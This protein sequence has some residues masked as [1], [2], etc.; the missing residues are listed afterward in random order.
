LKPENILIEKLS[1]GIVIPIIGDFGIS[2][3]DLETLK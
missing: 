3:V 2:K 1:N